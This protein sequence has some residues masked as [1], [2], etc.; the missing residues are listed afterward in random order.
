MY[1]TRGPGFVL[2]QVPRQIGMPKALLAHPY[3][4]ERTPGE[5]G[6]LCFSDR[7]T[8]RDVA[9]SMARPP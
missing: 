5:V 8:Q 2:G 9:G 6:R 3:H 1:V 4:Q 7:D